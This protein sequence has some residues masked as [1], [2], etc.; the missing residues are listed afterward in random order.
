MNSL[1]HLYKW[2][3]IKLPHDMTLE[4]IKQLEIKFY[5]MGIRTRLEV[6]QKETALLV[7]LKDY[8]V[9]KEVV[10]GTVKAVYTKHQEIYRVFESNLEYKN[11]K[12]YDDP[13]SARNKKVRRWNFIIII[14][15][16]FAILTIFKMING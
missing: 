6:E 12:L 1:E 11:E 5:E 13:Y 14:A 2:A 16:F 8:D 4:A 15:L 9:A 10:E 3:S 7:P